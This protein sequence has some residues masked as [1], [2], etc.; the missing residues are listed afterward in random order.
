MSYP[1]GWRGWW[2]EVSDQA[3][4][5]AWASAAGALVAN[6]GNA[7]MF[8]TFL[9][10]WIVGREVEQWPPNQER[11]WDPYCDYGFFAAGLLTGWLAA[12]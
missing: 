10:G 9:V 4:H 2:R 12:A 5:F 8:G 7:G 6:G 11:P 1:S 3:L